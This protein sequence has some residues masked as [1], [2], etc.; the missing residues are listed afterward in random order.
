MKFET[1]KARMNQELT[2]LMANRKFTKMKHHYDQSLQQL[3]LK[4]FNLAKY[5]DQILKPLVDQ[6]CILKDTFDFVN[7][8]TNI[9]PDRDK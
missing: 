1:S 7:K 9:N 6:E 5:L 8:I 2:F 4:T 3:V